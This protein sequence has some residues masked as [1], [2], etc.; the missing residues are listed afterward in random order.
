MADGKAAPSI[1]PAIVGR[2][3][4][5]S[6][7]RAFLAI[8][9]ILVGVQF[10]FLLQKILL[11]FVIGLFV[12]TIIHPG[13]QALRRWG[14]PPGIGILLHYAAF[15]GLAAFLVVSL[16]PIIAEQLSELAGLATTEVNRFLAD[17]VLNLPLLGPETNLRLTHLVQQTLQQLSIEQFPD[18]L[19]QFSA[20]LTTMA[21][22]SLQLA[23]GVAGSVLRFV[24]DLF[25]VLLFAFFLQ[26]RREETL[27]WVCRFL[28][29]RSQS[30]VRRKASLIYAKLSQWAKGQLI[31]CCVIGLLVFIV[32]TVLRIPYALT[33]A[34]LAGFT[35][36]IPYAGPLIAAAPAVIIT[37]TQFG[38]GW[39][40]AIALCYYGVQWS[41]NNIIVPLI[42]R[43]AV[44]LSPVAIVFAMLVGVSF[45]Q[46][47]HP[48]V[49]LLLAIPTTA[50]L[51]VFLDDFRTTKAG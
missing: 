47:I 8:L 16:V 33:L 24:V 27:D 46:F 50:V 51:S 25:V 39:A 36:F 7:T 11:L 6:V 41:E 12:A 5:S 2:L 34:I 14:I 45:P 30:F 10:V 37:L 28:P 49:G 48:I 42:M 9:L 31:L 19:R 35:E 1:P 20:R 17:P 21:S 26:I 4:L 44:E 29:P 15:L 13:V 18:T 40:V 43:H 22:G 32:L 3:S 23:T 38:L